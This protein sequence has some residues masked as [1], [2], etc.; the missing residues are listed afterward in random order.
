[1]KK[2]FNFSNNLFIKS[3]RLLL[4]FTVFMGTNS[5]VVLGAT[6]DLEISG[7]IPYWKVKEGVADARKHLEDLDQIH[8]FVFSVKEDG[9]LNDLGNIKKS[10]WT[11]L[12]REAKKEK[13]RV[14][15]TVMWS[16]TENIHRILSNP[17]LRKN[18]V[19]AI[20][21]MVKK[22]KYDGVD[23]DYEGKK[24]E[25]KDYYSMFL[26][27]LKKAIGSKMLVCTIE[28]RTP[29]ASLYTT[30]P[31]TLQYAND[32]AVIGSVCDRIQLMTYDQQRADLQLNAARMGSPYIP[33]GDVDW[34]RKVAELAITLLPKEKIVLG[35]AT[36]GREWAVQV[37]PDWYRS[38]VQVGAINHTDAVKKAKDLKIDIMR[39][40]AGE[41]SFTY[42]QDPAT[43]KL[44]KNIK[45]PKNTPKSDE[46]AAKALAYANQTGNTVFFNIVWWSDAKA[47]KQKIDLA[48]KLGLR[49]IAIFKIDGGEDPLIWDMIK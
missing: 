12:I 2:H 21:S 20:A 36:Y 35:V 37:S 34:V 10:P 41:A 42:I 49:G 48:E 26:T 39:N 23:I 3:L 6:T 44:L 28:A 16:N 9:T 18:H 31:T 8:P 29:A 32:Y 45:I 33:V 25:T 24:A 30:I 46:A 47:I 11:R 38:Y 1:M 5:S 22:G 15:P 7:W 40:S 27:E 14:I 13:V 4:I 19:E 17:N 43:Q